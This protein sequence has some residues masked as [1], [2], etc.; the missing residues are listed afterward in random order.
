MGKP[1]PE[2]YE[3]FHKNYT[4]TN[5]RMGLKQYL[6]P[7][8]I[9][10]HPGSTLEDAVELALRLKQGRFI[11]DQTQ[12]FYPTPGTLAAAMYHTGL[13]PRT[14][15]PIPVARGEREKRL[16]RALLHFDRPESRPLVREAL[17]KAGREDLIGKGAGCLVR[18]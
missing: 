9:S 15:R 16:Q 18:E 10:G 13:D 14:M 12:D 3:T 5:R 11:P 1:G 2:A 17:R 4:E 7:Y 8:Y 6:I